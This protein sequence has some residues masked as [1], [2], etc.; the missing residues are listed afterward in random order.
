[1]PTSTE[2][3]DLLTNAASAS[4]VT[5][6]LTALGFPSSDPM[7]AFARSAVG[8][9]EDVSDARIA[10]GAGALRAVIVHLN[11]A[12][13]RDVLVRIAR[14]MATKAPHLLWLLV[15]RGGDTVGLACW[16]ATSTTPA[17]SALLVARDHVTESDAESLGALCAA[18]RGDDRMVHG[19]WREILGREALSQRFYRALERCVVRL[20]EQAQGNAP[21][22]VRRELS[23]LTT[24]RLLFLGFLEGR[25]WLNGD[26]TFLSHAL[27]G[28]LTAGQDVQRRLL[29]P[30]FFGTLNTPPL[31]RAPA[32]KRFGR[33][34]FLN[35]GLFQRTPL[36]M[37]WRTTHFQND[38]LAALGEDVL[39]RYRFTSREDDAG[40]SELAID[41]EMLGRA[42]ES[43][44]ASDERRV[45][46]TFYTP[47]SL[48]E[49]VTDAAFRDALG[50]RGVDAD[51]VD[52]AVRGAPLDAD[53]SHALAEVLA[54]I[55][56]LDPACGSGA[57]LVHAVD[58]LSSFARAAGDGADE[59][60]RR[61]RIVARNIF[62][63]DLHPTA[64]WLCELR[65]WLSV[66]LECTATD[67]L[68]VP[69]LPNL[70]HNVRV[71]DTLRAPSFDVWRPDGSASTTINRLH[72]RYAASS[73]ARKRALGQALDRHVQRCAEQVLSTTLT[74]L[75][76]QRR[77]LV[78]A[79]RGRD[80]FGGRRGAVGDEAEAL[81]TLRAR[82][83]ACRQRL[84]DVRDG[85]AIPFSF[86]SHFPDAAANGGFDVVL[87]NPPW[88]RLHR[89]PADVRPELKRTFRVYREAAWERGATDAGAGRG[90]SAQVDLAALFIERAVGLV[91]E[92]GTMALLVPAKLWRSLAGG[93]VR[94]LCADWNKLQLLEDWSAAPAS[95]DAAV[96]PS[97]VVVR[98]GPATDTVRHPV[99]LCLHRRDLAISWQARR[100][101]VSLDDSPGAPWLILPPDART[102]FDRIAAA[103]IPLAI[104]G[105]GRP[106]LGVK[107][108]CNEAYLVRVLDSERGDSLVTDGTRRGRVENVV[109]R[110]VLRGEAVRAWVRDTRS[111]AMLYP[112]TA[113]GVALAELPPGARTWL[114]P[115]RRR[116]M[117]RSDARS[118][119][120]WWSLFRLEGA[121]AATPRVVWADMA[122][123]PGALVLESGDPT[124][125]LNSCYVLP[126]RDRLDAFTFAAWLNSP[127]AAAWLSVV[128]EPARG[129]YHRFMAWTVGRLPVPRDWARAREV[130]GPLGERASRGEPVGPS[131]LVDAAVRAF[132]V[133]ATSVCELIAWPA[134]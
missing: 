74:S 43:L 1:M 132:R 103:G 129:G 25:G 6:L 52:A 59:T 27:D 20:A 86:P 44:M 30:L 61:A 49:R 32:A 22:H 77:D 88:V 8:I 28:C 117:S 50:F 36:E 131:E 46:G 82:A 17:V 4:G 87:G 89:I 130:L 60:T 12:P 85:R 118:G 119:Q 26:R 39:F 102:A 66:V 67:P 40:W 10:R 114:T 128:A 94:R 93:G 21:I 80:L 56:V 106:T 62:G 24:S 13:T 2:L 64:V 65:L 51:I 84:R 23:L 76:A 133:R 37:R 110:P 54:T 11:E 127:L 95:F 41:P 125:A 5:A 70:D 42:F 122:R 3:Q 68:R 45:T 57:F 91:R 113:S 15:A 112:H 101:D 123:A 134:R 33:I 107:S 121:L 18:S 29:E 75:A 100:A 90:F 35:G 79:A 55:R 14:R 111:E 124:V 92:G 31:R 96:Y 34:P 109:L 48:V 69:A 47:Q 126:C 116:L 120:A 98:R 71:G 105:L 108:G 72:L 16:S 99:T 104:S 78:V 115:Y 38:D 7:D 81:A 58:R 19:R 53:T 83:R 9:P 63:V 97:L 73:G